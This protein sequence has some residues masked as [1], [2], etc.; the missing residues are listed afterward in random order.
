MQRLFILP[1]IIVLSIFLIP[2]MAAQHNSL[3][4]KEAAEGW[5][6]LFDGRTTDGWHGFKM[7]GLPAGWHVEDGCLVTSGEGD[8]LRGDII[9]VD[10]YED[11]E[12]YIEWAISPG[13][14]SGVFLHVVEGDYPSAMPPA[15][16]IN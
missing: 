14:N 8:D 6:L 4:S 3:T 1:Q 15:L 9:T 16:N 10:Q 12:L 2:D 7:K 11:F 13:G 5:V